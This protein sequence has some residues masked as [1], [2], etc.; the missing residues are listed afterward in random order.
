MLLPFWLAASIAALAGLVFTAFCVRSAWLMSESQAKAQ[1]SV[2]FASIGTLLLEYVVNHV[3]GVRD[4]RIVGSG[5][6]FI[7][8]IAR[9]VV[10]FSMLESVIFLFRRG[11][12]VVGAQMLAAAI[13]TVSLTLL[14]DADRAG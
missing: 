12:R 2:L 3:L 4:V 9:M 1:R 13:V 14:A 10:V 11:Y 7:G 5:V 6:D 8:D